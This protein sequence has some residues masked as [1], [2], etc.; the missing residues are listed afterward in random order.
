MMVRS[1]HLIG[2]NIITGKVMSVIIKDK[3]FL[4]CLKETILDFEYM[5]FNELGQE[6][7]DDMRVMYKRKEMCVRTVALLMLYITKK[8]ETNLNIEEVSLKEYS[9]SKQIKKEHKYMIKYLEKYFIYEKL[10]NGMTSVR[11]KES[12]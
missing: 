9:A 11:T 4:K 5:S 3:K 6:L 8:L 7:L 12:F 2:R 10:A 1:S